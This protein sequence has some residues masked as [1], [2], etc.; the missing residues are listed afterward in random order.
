MASVIVLNDG[1]EAASTF[2]R[3]F[4][5]SHGAAF[6]RESLVETSAVLGLLGHLIE[7]LDPEL[8][9]AM[10]SDPLMARHTHAMSPVMT[11]VTHECRSAATARNWLRGLSRRHPAA[12]VYAAA[13]FVI[14]RRSAILLALRGPE[15][16]RAGSAFS[17]V[18]EHDP[19]HTS[20]VV[21]PVV[22]GWLR[23]LPPRALLL[24]APASVRKE[25]ADVPALWAALDDVVDIWEHEPNEGAS[26]AAAPGEEEAALAASKR[27]ELSTAELQSVARAL[28]GSPAAAPGAAAGST[29][30]AA[31]IIIGVVIVGAV[32][33]H[34]MA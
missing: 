4:L 23:R 29:L 15:A 5:V 19:R 7:T 27:G 20:A 3:R 16:T 28:G 22:D 17:T 14:S 25:L 30:A 2:L 26:S 6:C 33:V 12:V 32:V 21:L 10:H 8:A 31:A 13:A 18:R 24:T 11:W 34:A 1:A 9:A